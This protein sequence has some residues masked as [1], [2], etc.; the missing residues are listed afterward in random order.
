[1]E[2][3]EITVRLLAWACGGFSA[4]VALRQMAPGYLAALS[5]GLAILFCVL[6]LLG[7]DRLHR[8]RA[9]PFAVFLVLGALYAG[10]FTERVLTPVFALTESTVETEAVALDGVRNHGRYRTLELRFTLPEGSFNARLYDYG[11]EVPALRA[12][13]RLSGAFRLRR[14]DTLHGKAY[15]S[16]LSQGIVMLAYPAGEMTVTPDMSLFA[17]PRRL[18]RTIETQVDTLFPEDVRPFEKALLMGEKTDYY[19]DDAL[20]RTVSYAGLA[21]VVAVSGMHVAFVAGLVTS[22]LHLRRAFLAGVPAVVLFMLMTGMTPSVVRAGILYLA[23]LLAPALRRESDGATTLLFALA[24]LLL[25]NPAAVYSISLQ[26]S[27]ASVAGIFLFADRMADWGWRRVRLWTGNPVLRRLG[28]NVAQLAAVSLSANVFT[29]PLAAWHFGYI[30]VYGLLTNL[31]TYFVIASIFAGGYL[32]CGLGAIVPAAGR[33]LAW[34]VALGVRYVLLCAQVVAALPGSVL[35]TENPI[36]AE[37]MVLVFLLFG[38]AWL[39]KGRGRFRPLFPACLSVAALCLSCMAVNAAAARLAPRITVLDVGQG[40]SVLFLA[41]GRAVVVDCGGEG[42]LS[43]AGET[44]GEYLLSR[45]VKRLDALVLTHLHADHTDGVGTLLELVPADKLILAPGLD[46]SDG[47]E[48]SLLDAAEKHGAELCLVTEDMR[49]VAGE[50]ELDILAPLGDGDENER[51]LIILGGMDGYEALIT[52]DA[53]A[54]TERALIEHADLAGAE[55]LV[56]G[57]HGSRFSTCLELVEAMRPES[58]VISVGY[59]SYGH[60][61]A[62]AIRRATSFGAALYRTDLNGHVTF[63]IGEDH[64]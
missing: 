25:H 27:F 18:A 20:A 9:I 58:V 52:G 35:Y 46:D 64:G 26:L 24:A 1:L 62:E 60:P 39:T 38:L 16:Y 57:H 55:M 23:L 40:E 13:D 43:N 42:T 45:G 28:R 41:E 12:G 44:V 32:A 19:A 22:H 29:A 3:S 30:A 10:A 6:S 11:G 48:H 5:I 8:R 49:L 17:L 7:R 36:Y 53:G 31:L 14:A 54:S 34:V 15:T 4:G 51:G 59:N 50:I 56:A 61:T 33:L 21:H 63:F 2:H 47:M 37:W